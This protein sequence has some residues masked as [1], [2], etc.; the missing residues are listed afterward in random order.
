LVNFYMF[1]IGDKVK[2]VRPTGGK[3]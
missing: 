3:H 1:K 2:L